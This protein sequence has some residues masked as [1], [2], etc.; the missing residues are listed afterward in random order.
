MYHSTR[1]D[2]G[3]YVQTC[4]CVFVCFLQSDLL[5]QALIFESSNPLTCICIYLPFVRKMR[6]LL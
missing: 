2:V 5:L 6:C 4:V 3:V 1:A